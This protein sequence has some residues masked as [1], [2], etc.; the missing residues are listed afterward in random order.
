MGGRTQIEIE[1]S[2][3]GGNPKPHH[4]LHMWAR[5]DF[6]R[7]TRKGILRV[8]NGKDGTTGDKGGFESVTAQK[9]ADSSLAPKIT[10]DASQ[11][12]NMIAQNVTAASPKGEMRALNEIGADP[13][14][15]TELEMEEKTEGKYVVQS[16]KTEME[17]GKTTEGKVKEWS[18]HE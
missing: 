9:V 13:V 17:M 7:P 3:I 16:N 11:S 8:W 1:G 18:F 14:N 15:K 4:Q 5:E 2:E 10:E 12:G 6:G